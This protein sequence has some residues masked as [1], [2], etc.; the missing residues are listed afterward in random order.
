[1]LLR[2]DLGSLVIFG[3]VLL[4][5]TLLFRAVGAVRLKETFIRLR[6]KLASSRQGREEKR[7]FEQLQLCV[8]QVNG[9]DEWWRTICQ[10]AQQL[11]LAWVSLHVTKADGGTET[12]VW[13]R[14]NAPPGFTHIV[15]MSFPLNAGLGKEPAEFEMAVLINGSLESANHR[16][17]LFTRLVDECVARDSPAVSRAKGWDTNLRQVTWGLCERPANPS[18]NEHWHQVDAGQGSPPCDASL[19][20]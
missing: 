4:L 14:P 9:S 8:R 15:T 10:A 1:M 7:T 19:P 12:S 17:G 18:P 6:E 13:R 3:C 2:E 5:I 16:A 11:G 20:R